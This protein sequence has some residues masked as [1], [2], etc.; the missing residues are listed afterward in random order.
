MPKVF[1]LIWRGLL[2]VEAPEPDGST[3]S[4]SSEVR[5]IVADFLRGGGGLVLKNK[6]RLKY[7]FY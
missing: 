3:V 7:E 4:A 1:V 2:G 5:T 6:E